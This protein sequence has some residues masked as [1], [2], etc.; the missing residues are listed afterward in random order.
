M[1]AIDTHLTYIRLTAK[2]DLIDPVKE[3]CRLEREIQLQTKEAFNELDADGDGFISQQEIEA[4]VRENLDEDLE[5][6]DPL[7]ADKLVRAIAEDEMHQIDT[8]AD[9]KISSEEFQAAAAADKKRKEDGQKQMSDFRKA[10]MQAKQTSQEPVHESQEPVHE[11]GLEVVH[12]EVHPEAADEH[13]PVDTG[14]HAEAEATEEYTPTEEAQHVEAA[15]EHKEASMLD[16]LKNAEHAEIERRAAATHESELRQ[17]RIEAAKKAEEDK[18]EA[19]RLHSQ[20]EEAAIA[21]AE[22]QHAEEE[23]A[24]HEADRIAAEEEAAHVAAEAARIADEQEAARLAAEDEAEAERLRLFELRQ[25]ELREAR[26]AAAPEAMKTVLLL[27]SELHIIQQ[28]IVAAPKADCRPESS[29][30][31]QEAELETKIEKLSPKGST[32][33][34]WHLEEQELAEALDSIHEYPEPDVSQMTSARLKEAEERTSQRQKDKEQRAKSKQ[35]RDEQRMSSASGLEHQKRKIAESYDR[36]K[37]LA[38][39]ICANLVCRPDP[40]E[41][42][43][44]SVEKDGVNACALSPTSEGGSRSPFSEGSPYSE[45]EDV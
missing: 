7:E 40:I 43:F 28:E 16:Q 10:R 22:Q 24:R 41:M 45:G 42:V 34:P 18:A 2:R 4:V 25:A 36:T 39:L 23:A 13:H 8:D 29:L 20:L 15:D 9:S 27:N 44:Q 6:L 1:K 21:E 17:A 32:A 26:Y 31:L 11:E 33:K 38:A 37:E 12:S 35:L 14:D 19:A 5:N 30:R 3:A